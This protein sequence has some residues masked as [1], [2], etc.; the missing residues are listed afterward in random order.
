L[1]ETVTNNRFCGTLGMLGEEETGGANVCK[2]LQA[3]EPLLGMSCKAPFR[4]VNN[5]VTSFIINMLQSAQNPTIHAVLAH[6][7]QFISAN[8]HG[9]YT[10]DGSQ[11]GEY[12]GTSSLSNRWQVP[13]CWGYVEPLQAKM[14]AILRGDG[15][16]RTRGLEHPWSQTRDGCVAGSGTK[17]I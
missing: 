2:S 1:G 15:F 3:S 12:N 10:A 9:Y 13:G 8:K 16:R 11:F 4:T 5:A 6:R 17:T 14:D 7:L